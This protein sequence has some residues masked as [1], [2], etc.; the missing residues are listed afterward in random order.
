MKESLLSLNGKVA[1]VTG[2][3]GFLGKEFCETLSAQGADVAVVD[4]SESDCKKFAEDLAKKHK[5]KAIGVKADIT[6]KSEVEK[7]VSEIVKKRGRID[8]LVNNAAVKT[9]NF[10]APFESYPLEDWEQAM[11]VNLTGAFL[12]SQ[13]VGKEMLKRRKGSVINIASVYG[14]QPPD[15][16]IYEGSKI[17]TPAVYT[18][19]KAGLIGLTKYLAEYWAENGIRV[20]SI[21]PGGVFNNQEKEFVKKYAQKVPLG[22]MANKNELNGTLLFLASDDSSYVTGQNLIVDGGLTIW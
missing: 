6:K 3:T 17:N 21:S 1:V 19:S 7:A 22:R 18:A 12:F 2:G 11:A 14:V 8:I 5:T 15:K 4:L 20:N 10:Y 13:A 9:K 16:K